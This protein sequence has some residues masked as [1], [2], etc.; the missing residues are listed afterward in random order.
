MKKAYFKKIL[1]EAKAIK[2]HHDKLEECNFD[3]AKVH[4]ST[5][6]PKNSLFAKYTKKR[7]YLTRVLDKIL[8]FK[9]SKMPLTIT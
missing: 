6:K 9:L 1:V 5:I 2:Q 7:V 3:L 4:R 8:Y